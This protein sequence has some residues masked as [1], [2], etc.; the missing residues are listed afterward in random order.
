MQQRDFLLIEATGLTRDSKGEK[1]G[2][3]LMHSVS[4]PGIFPDLSQLG[5][6][7]EEISACYIDRQ[8]GSNQ[9]EMYCRSFLNPRGRPLNRLTAVLA[10]EAL[11]K[12]AGSD[13]SETLSDS[14]SKW[15][16]SSLHALPGVR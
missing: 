2:Y 9:V 3:F 16:F 13:V 15:R 8:L 6:V 5:L 10:A 7:R 12:Q 4:L 1:V 14:S 11:L